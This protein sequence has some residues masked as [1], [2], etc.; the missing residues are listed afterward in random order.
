LP[1][2]I[3]SGLYV[4]IVELPK[5]PHPLPLSSGFSNETAYRVL[6]FE[7]FSETSEAF[8][9]LSNDADQIWFISNRHIRTTVLNPQE[10]RLRI[11]LT[12]LAPVR[13]QSRSV[14]AIG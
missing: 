11:C 12:E 2:Y 5:G 14:M 1:C 6:G 8:L 10:T 7:S 13:P 4:R 9:V 3:E